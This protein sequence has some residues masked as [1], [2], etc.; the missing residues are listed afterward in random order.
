MATD[1]K[2]NRREKLMAL[3]DR[4]RDQPSFE[5]NRTGMKGLWANLQQETEN[6][7]E[8]DSGGKG[9]PQLRQILKNPKLRKMVVKFLSG[10]DEDESGVDDGPLK[11]M[12]LPDNLGLDRMGF[13]EE[14]STSSSLEEL[15]AY[16]VQ[17]ENRT[18]W[19]EAI[20]ESTLVELERVGRFIEA[21]IGGE[22]APDSVETGD[23][24]S[25]VPKPTNEEAAEEGTGAGDGKETKG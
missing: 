19:L 22:K 9:K 15:E 18:D 14:L 8:G 20:L 5:G 3:R 7:G 25:S 11:S 13:S 2:A 21:A 4:R 16:K 12:N 6:A 17:L 24:P 10:M 23:V 1:D